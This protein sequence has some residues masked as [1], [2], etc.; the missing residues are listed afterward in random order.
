MLVDLWNGTAMDTTGVIGAAVPA[1]GV[2]MYRI[3]VSGSSAPSG[4]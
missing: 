1:H 3:S 4:R 2:V